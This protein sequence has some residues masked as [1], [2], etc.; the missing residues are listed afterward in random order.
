MLRKNNHENCVF[1]NSRNSLLLSNSNETQ[2]SFI[3]NKSSSNDQEDEQDDSENTVS[4]NNSSNSNRNQPPHQLPKR[5]VN[6]IMPR[7]ISKLFQ[8]RIDGIIAHY[9][10]NDVPLAET[11]LDLFLRL[12][13]IIF[14]SF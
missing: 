10:A 3:T 6:P 1:L 2:D 13:F 4:E 5:E 9:M 14:E 11:L 8:Y 7:A 12:S